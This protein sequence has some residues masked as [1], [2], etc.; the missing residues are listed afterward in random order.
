[1]TVAPRALIA[2]SLISGAVSGVTTVQATPNSLQHQAKPCNFV[3]K[4][5]SIPLSYLGKVA[6][7]GRTHAS[8]CQTCLVRDTRN[9]IRCRTHLERSL[10]KIDVVKQRGF[11]RFHLWAGGFPVLTRS[12]PECHWCH[13]GTWSGDFGSPFRRCSLLHTG[14]RSWWGHEDQAFWTLNC[15]GDR[16][17][18]SDLVLYRALCQLSMFIQPGLEFTTCVQEQRYWIPL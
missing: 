2:E 17:T 8:R 4:N 3:L 1:M 14:S 10:T 13:P 9:G 12:Q 16:W 11:C 7:R 5:W 15:C 18:H 6:C